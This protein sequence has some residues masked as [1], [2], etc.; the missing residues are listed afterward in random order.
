MRKGM[1]KRPIQMVEVIFST[2]GAKFFIWYTQESNIAV[3]SID[4]CL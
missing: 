4:K 2:E 1:G 3:H